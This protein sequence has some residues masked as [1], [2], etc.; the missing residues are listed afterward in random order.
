[1]KVL[2]VIQRF[3]PAIG[4]S[5]S[6]CFRAC[7]FLSNKGI[8]SKVAT[9]NL[10]NIEDFFKEPLPENEY[11]RLGEADFEDG[12][13]IRRYPL[14]SLYSKISSMKIINFMLKIGFE[15]TEA[16][17]IFKNSPHSFQMY[18]SLF[19]EAKEA[20]I[21]HLHTLP[22]FHNLVGFFVAKIMRKK[23]IITPHFHPGNNYYER[24]LFFRLMKQCDAVMTMSNYEKEYLAK[25]GINSHRIY[26]TGNSIDIDQKQDSVNLDDYRAELFRKHNINK[27]SKIIIFVGKKLLYK[28]VDTLIESARRFSEVN[29]IYTCL[30]L[31]GPGT[32]SPGLRN[33]Y[34]NEST[35]FKIVDF[36]PISDEEKELLLSLSD[37]LVLASEFEAFGIVF[38]EAWK[39]KKPVI[40]SNRGAMPEVIGDAGLCVEYGNVD[41]LKEK[42][43]MILCDERLA[44]SLAQ[45]GQ[46]KLD[47]YSLEKIGNK[48]F[49]VHLAVRNTKIRVLLVSHLFPPYCLG[50]SE[51][52]AYEQAKALRHRGFDIRVFAGKIDDLQERYGI[53]REKNC[54][55]VTRVN[56]HN[57]D[58]NH[59]ASVNF[60]KKELQDK[61]SR[62]LYETAPDIVHFHNIY[63]FSLKMINEVHK[64]HIPAV[65]TLHDYWPICFKNILI[66]D[67]GSVCEKKGKDC[68]WCHE[69]PFIT[70]SNPDSLAERNR[71]FMEYL[72]KI[73][74][75]ISPS[76]YLMHR[77]IECGIPSGKIQMINN[78]I[79][80]S[81]FRGINK[82]RLFSKLT[83]G[84]VGQIIEHKGIENFLRA[85]SLLNNQERGCL[86]VL[87]FGT[88]EKAFVEYCKN[89]AR[90]LRLG[91]IV[92]FCGSVKNSKINQVYEKIDVLVV[93]SVWP[94]NSP[95]TIMESLASGTPVLASHI[96][97]IPELIKDGVQGY[98]H[99]YNSVPSLSENIKKIIRD[100]GIIKKMKQNC[101][102][103]AS[104]FDLAKQAKLISDNYYRIIGINQN[105]NAA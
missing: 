28:G 11:V 40:G 9:I 63:S 61:F 62:V 5:E 58:F 4:G 94:E 92:K 79:N 42:L 36:G 73:D 67:N 91:E 96:G 50:G 15:K 72:M 101:I 83:L 56:L 87:I 38:L 60:D 89:L 52:V 30:F 76:N 12:V 104:E 80:V 88:G 44:H 46:K 45:A 70:G 103:M 29:N 8:V 59:L 24:K 1:M 85:L 66:T 97:G 75:L 26:V 37:V 31:V 2:N 20:D 77:F 41:D 10:H 17:K 43:K 25:K 69:R 32:V 14:T 54:F 21:V 102:A 100:P 49:S 33:F 7:R 74:T 39:F 95:V 78:G 105:K 22:Y 48:I 81:K 82:R 27:S 19:K 18:L 47:D 13:F 98:L 90:E 86:S 84:Y 57:A 65:M 6:W 93:P 23:I 16:G 35:K 55:K 3:P 34:E 64:M 53:R 68:G 71:Y 99:Q 51:I